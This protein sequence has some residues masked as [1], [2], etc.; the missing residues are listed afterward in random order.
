MFYELFTKSLLLEMT[1][2]N[3]IRRLQG[4]VILPESGATLAPAVQV[5]RITNRLFTVTLGVPMVAVVGVDLRSGIMATTM[6]VIIPVVE[7]CC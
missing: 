3:F 2:E 7:F 6:V 5:M 4:F 1:H